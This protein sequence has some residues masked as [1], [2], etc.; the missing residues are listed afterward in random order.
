MDIDDCISKCREVA[1][2][3][4]INTMT[5]FAN[6]TSSSCISLSDIKSAI[7]ARGMPLSTFVLKDSKHFPNSVILKATYNKHIVVK[8][9]STGTFQITGAKNFKSASIASTEASRIVRSLS[10]SDTD[11][12]TPVPKPTFV[13]QMINGSFRIENHICLE[14]LYTEL[15]D[16]KRIFSMTYE[17]SDHPAINLKLIDSIGKPVTA[18]IFRTG[19][20]IITGASNFDSLHVMLI[21]VMA[22]LDSSCSCQYAVAAVV[23]APP[24]KR[25]RKRKAE[26]DMFYDSVSLL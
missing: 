10:C 8:V 19:S 14:Q 13:V 24:K 18:L 5:L 25:G 22:L 2:S 6:T 1:P 21:D 15:S 26:S 23:K 12:A 11:E 9:F 16:N 3:F 4:K 17:K 7:K 20:V